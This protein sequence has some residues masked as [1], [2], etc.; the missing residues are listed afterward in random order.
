MSDDRAGKRGHVTLVVSIAGVVV[1]VVMVGLEGFPLVISCGE[2][3]VTRPLNVAEGLQRGD[4]SRPLLCVSSL[5]LG[6][7]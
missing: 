6:M 7:G 4:E 2:S 3:C 1:A 5:L